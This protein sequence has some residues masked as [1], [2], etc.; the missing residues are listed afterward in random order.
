MPLLG[1]HRG[2]C[3]RQHH[4]APGLPAMPVS[5]CAQLGVQSCRPSAASSAKTSWALASSHQL[6]ITCLFDASFEHLVRAAFLEAVPPRM[7]ASEP[8]KPSAIKEEVSPAL[9][10]T[11][12]RACLFM[13]SCLRPCSLAG[14]RAAR[15][16]KAPATGDPARMGSLTNTRLKISRLRAT[17]AHLRRSEDR[18]V[19]GVLLAQ[20]CASEAIAVRSGSF[21]AAARTSGPAASPSSKVRVVRREP[22]TVSRDQPVWG[23]AKLLRVEV[24]GPVCD[25]LERSGWA[26]KQCEWAL[27]DSKRRARGF[28]VCGGLCGCRPVPGWR[29]VQEFGI[30]L[31]DF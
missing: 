27:Q 13:S 31:L 29:C 24:P 6:P 18:L 23:H 22:L 14:P 4:A 9:F 21:F 10:R 30:H 8:S 19:R 7:H 12:W 26:R 28:L 25:C 20:R 2:E 16:T 15:T 11:T 3:K 1:T 17:Q 5:P